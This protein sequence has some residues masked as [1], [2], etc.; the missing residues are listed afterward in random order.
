VRRMQITTPGVLRSGL[1][2]L[3]VLAALALPGCGSSNKNESSSTSPT[4]NWVDGFCGAIAKWKGSLE[5]AGSTFKNVDE[6]AKA[7]VEQATADISDANGTLGADL[8]ALGRPPTT[9]TSKAK[10]ELKDLR[11]KIESSVSQIKD[12]TQN[13]SSATNL[14]TAVNTASAALLTISTDISTSLARLESLD[15]REAWKQAFA[16]SE[17]CNSLGK[18]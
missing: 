10:D 6:P 11:S 17:A 3:L 16:D 18:S 14:L 15:A 5:S 1:A 9:G 2:A 13:I 4:A 12:A 8:K 7:K